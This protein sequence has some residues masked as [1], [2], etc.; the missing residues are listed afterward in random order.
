MYEHCRFSHKLHYFYILPKSIQTSYI[1]TFVRKR[2]LIT[3]ARID[4]GGLLVV[5]NIEQ[6]KKSLSF[7]NLLY[8]MFSLVLSCC[9][10][11]L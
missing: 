3:K 2:L 9:H 4:Q 6:R 1:G 8:L 7:H 10:Q 11:D 5:S